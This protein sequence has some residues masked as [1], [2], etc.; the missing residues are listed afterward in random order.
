VT[1]ATGD[2]GATG[3][4]GD[5]GATGAT[6]TTGATG[7]T[8]ATGDVGATGTTGATG[9]VGAT[10]A[11]G[12]TGA[13]GV[14]GATGPIPSGS[15]TFDSVTTGAFTL[16]TPVWDDLRFPSNAIN[17]PGSVSAPTRNS[18]TAL[19]EFSGNSDN[20]I[21]GIA[22]MPHSWLN[23]TDVHPH[24]HLRFP[25]ANNLT[26]RWQFEYDL[27]DLTTDFTNSY[28]TYTLLGTV[29]AVNPNNTHQEVLVS[30]GSLPMVGFTESTLIAWRITRLANSDPLDNDPSDIVLLEFDIHFEVYRL[31]SPSEIP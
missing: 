13:T 2:V 19:L 21:A 23:G 1:G 8:G 28:G 30:F 5:V 17:P 6:G 31:G 3:A 18:T 14:T 9:D 11:T 27:A 24:L 7:V 10:G 25:T 16:S 22:Q 12:T 4:T 29:S 15:V 26:S 20:I